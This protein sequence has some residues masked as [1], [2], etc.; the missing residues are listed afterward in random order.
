MMRVPLQQSTR[1][2]RSIAKQ[3]TAPVRGVNAKESFDKMKDGDA[4]S[5][6]NWFS[7][8]SYI[9]T[10]LGSEDFSTMS[11]TTGSVLTL[12]EYHSGATQKFIACGSGRIDDITSG[13]AVN[14]A[15]GLSENR[16]QYENFGG[17]LFMVNGTDAPRD[18]DGTTL[19]STAWTGPTIADLIDV[20]AF[21]A[22]LYFVEKDSQ[23]FWYGGNQAITGA[24][25]EFDLGLV[26]NFRGNLVTIKA[27]TQD[28][29]DGIDDLFAAIFSEGDVVIYQGSDPGSNFFQV[30][31]FKI[32]R[33]IGQRCAERI[34]SDVGVITEDGY[35]LL[36]EV[37]PFGRVR[38]D[39]DFS[40]GYEREVD[41]ATKNFKSNIGWEIEMYPA[42]SKIFINIPK[43]STSSLQHVVNTNTKAWTAFE[44]P[45]TPE[46]W[47]VYN[48]DIYFGSAS[49]KIYKAET[50]TSDDGTAITATAQDGWNYLGNRTNTKR[51]L[52]AR[53]IFQLEADATV[54]TS[55][56]VDF[57]VDP[58]FSP[59]TLD[60]QGDG[61][62]VWNEAVWDVDTWGGAEQTAQDWATLTGVG[63]ACSLGFKVTSS[64]QQF[65]WVATTY[66]Y[67]PG[68]II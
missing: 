42:G 41:E 57:E 15:T 38:S 11:A 13:T 48:G 44:Y 58:E 32:G 1:Q 36:T 8:E 3:I 50:G 35:I 47:G 29:G 10:R 28:G 37:L 46:T 56:L 23:S 61:N 17:K 51:F 22:R 67:E 7:R 19:A 33:P 59:L 18:Y 52:D 27:I 30:G 40:D 49:G 2:Q 60:V 64:T 62:A 55:L 63:Y 9:E 4:V 24:L 6:C 53:P 34:G 65:R 26:G 12:A 45:Q 5:L 39:K 66:V 20:T 21:K 14:K 54:S 16:W 43:S 68:G 31:T 25:T